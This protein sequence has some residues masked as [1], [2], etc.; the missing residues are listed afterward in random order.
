VVF[1]ALS[2]RSGAIDASWPDRAIAG[3]RSL[4]SVTSVAVA[5]MEVRTRVAPR[6][7][8]VLRRP[9]ALRRGQALFVEG[10]DEPVTGLI[11]PLA[12][13]VTHDYFVCVGTPIVAGRAFSASDNASAPAAAI[14]NAGAARRAFGSE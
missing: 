2:T 10:R 7:D 13:V 8:S 11:F 3:L 1:V 12:T 6:R 9:G 5:G 4:P 14:I